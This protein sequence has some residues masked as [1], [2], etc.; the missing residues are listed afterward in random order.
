MHVTIIER[1]AKWPK[2]HEDAADT[3]FGINFGDLNVTTDDASSGRLAELVT[4]TTRDLDAVDWY[5][6]GSTI[7]FRVRE[8]AEAFLRA[9]NLD[10]DRK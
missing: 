7:W 1:R 5:W 8:H 4:D 10:F 2:P 6:S 3:W 9:R